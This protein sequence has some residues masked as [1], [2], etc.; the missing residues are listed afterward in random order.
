M[1]T[2][3]KNAIAAGVLFIVGTVPALLSSV[4]LP[5]P[6]NLDDLLKFSVNEYQVIT[7]IFLMIVMA[8][9][10]AGIAISLFPVLK[11]YSEGLALGAVGFR[12]IE[13]VLAIV[14]AIMLMLQLI[15][16]EV[17]VKA[18]AP[19]SS[20]F[21]TIGTLLMV[22]RDWM[23]DVPA[24]LAWCIGALMYYFI[25]YQTKLIPRWLSAWGLVGIVLTIISSMLVLLRIVGFMSVIQGVLCMPILLQEMVLAVW[26]IVKGF[27]PSAI[28]S[29]SSKVE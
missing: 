26:L 29:L 8:F 9:A 12:I 18:G 11:K 3:R 28:A 27:N 6:N 24:L 7:K 22:G 14:C 21:H 5:V 23:R 16:S 17:F 13:G 1:N 25:F 19:D 2:Y 10:C 4:F 20:Y 15:L